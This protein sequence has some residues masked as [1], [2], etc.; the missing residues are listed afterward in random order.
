MI[1]DIFS[2]INEHPFISIA[3][4]FLVVY[5]FTHNPDT[6]HFAPFNVSIGGG[7]ITNTI[8]V[9]SGNGAVKP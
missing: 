7:D 8:S 4:I 3:V 9:N 1:D 5:L 2:Y 6:Y